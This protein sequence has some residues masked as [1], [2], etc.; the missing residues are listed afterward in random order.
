MPSIDMVHTPPIP[1]KSVNKPKFAV[2]F[3]SLT[4]PA[5]TGAEDGTFTL[6]GGTEECVRLNRLYDGKVNHFLVP[7]DQL[8]RRR[9]GSIAASPCTT[10]ASNSQPLDA[11][12]NGVEGGER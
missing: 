4:C 6:E 2:V 12:S 11:A 5:V 10:S 3:Q 8:K 7:A 9:N 1:S